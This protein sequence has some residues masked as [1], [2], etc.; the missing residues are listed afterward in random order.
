MK[1]F[2][3]AFRLH[4][5]FSGKKEEEVFAKK[6]F[7]FGLNLIFL[8]WTFSHFTN[9]G[10]LKSLWQHEY[11]KL[12]LNNLMIWLPPISP[13]NKFIRCTYVPKREDSNHVMCQKLNKSI[14]FPNRLH[15]SRLSKKGALLTKPKI[16]SLRIK[17]DM[18]IWKYL[19]VVEK[20]LFLILIL[21]YNKYLRFILKIRNHL[22]ENLQI[23]E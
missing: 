3:E 9:F 10:S 18:N 2:R 11:F 16:K 1:S 14:L 15:F 19:S 21:F 23:I 8:F 22:F 6:I 12:S 20:F 4:V 13:S 7:F 17:H 5:D